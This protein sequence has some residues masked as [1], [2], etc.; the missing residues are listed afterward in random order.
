MIQICYARKQKQGLRR[1]TASAPS[2]QKYYH[3]EGKCNYNELLLQTF[4]ERHEAVLE[5][6]QLSLGETVL[7]QIS[8]KTLGILPIQ[9]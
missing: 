7:H 3:L 5:A 8:L 9:W 2:G 4:S 6:R 1:Q